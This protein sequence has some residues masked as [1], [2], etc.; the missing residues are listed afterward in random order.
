MSL[1]KAREDFAE[2]FAGGQKPHDDTLRRQLTQEGRERFNKVLSS[3][4]A[5]GMAVVPVEAT[6]KMVDFAD[7]QF[8]WGPTGYD[9]AP[10]GQAFPHAVWSAM[11]SAYQEGEG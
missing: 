8:D 5:N 10:Q 9:C 2:G 7:E 11:L 3:L 4:K 6:K 1:E